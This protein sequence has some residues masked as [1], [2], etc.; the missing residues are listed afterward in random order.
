M[1]FAVKHASTAN[2][3]VGF[4]QAIT[5]LGSNAVKARPNQA[6][7]GKSRPAAVSGL[8]T[9]IIPRGKTAVNAIAMV[10]GPGKHHGRDKTKLAVIQNMRRNGAAPAWYSLIPEGIN[11]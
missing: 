2:V 4:G 8:A 9:P 11:G 10:G 5:R 6:V 1:T 7:L 3:R